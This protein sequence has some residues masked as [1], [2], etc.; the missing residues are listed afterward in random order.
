MHLAK[1]VLCHATL[2]LNKYLSITMCLYHLYICICL[3]IIY[4]SIYLPIYLSVYLSIY[5][6]YVP[7]HHAFLC[8]VPYSLINLRSVMCSRSHSYKLQHHSSNT[9][10][11]HFLW[12]I[13]STGLAYLGK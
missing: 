9:M 7:V 3:S 1:G 11:C 2:V 10:F 8:N 13:K 12:V 5:N 6:L 4:L